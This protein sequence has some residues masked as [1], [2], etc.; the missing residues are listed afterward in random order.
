MGSRGCPCFSKSGLRFST[1]QRTG[2]FPGH[3]DT[4][5]Q[6]TEGR[7]LPP[8]GLS[9]NSGGTGEG[10][11]GVYGC[12]RGGEWGLAQPL[13][14]G[15]GTCPRSS[16]D[17]RSAPASGVTVTGQT[18]CGRFSCGPHTWQEEVCSPESEWGGSSWKGEG[19]P[20][21]DGELERKG[22]GG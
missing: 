14:S 4:V 12:V 2:P 18:G 19:G 17:T 3:P 22:V 5:P 11:E 6:W 21:L 9:Q 15:N 13:V 7:W 8:N 1:T 10:V 16:W 20:W